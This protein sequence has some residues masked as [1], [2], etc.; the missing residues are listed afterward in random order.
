MDNYKKNKENKNEIKNNSIGSRHLFIG[1]SG[2][3]KSTLINQKILNFIKNNKKKPEIIMISPTFE[4]DKA[5]NPI[6][7]YA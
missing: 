2:T 5:Y 7:K 3:G 4:N 6:R 1:R